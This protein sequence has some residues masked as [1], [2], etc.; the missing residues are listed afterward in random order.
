MNELYLEVM[1]QH[2]GENRNR[3]GNKPDLIDDILELHESDPQFL[4][5]ADLKV[6]ILGPF[7]SQ[8]STR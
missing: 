7:L 6:N 8:H 3:N 4:P 5:E 2:T 1:Q